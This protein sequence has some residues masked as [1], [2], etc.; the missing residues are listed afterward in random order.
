[1]L[2]AISKFKR[3]ILTNCKISKIIQIS[4][5]D[6]NTGE[7]DSAPKLENWHSCAAV[8]NNKTLFFFSPTEKWSF[9]RMY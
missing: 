1:M 6:Q 9:N 4:D 7:N 3:V 8:N 5:F 2:I